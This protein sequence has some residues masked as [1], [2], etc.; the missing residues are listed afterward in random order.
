MIRSSCA[1]SGVLVI[2]VAAC[3][4]TAP[5][6]HDAPPMDVQAAL[7][8]IR[9]VPAFPRLTFIRPVWL[10]AAPDE[11][12]RL[13]VI[14]QPGRILS[15][16]NRNDVEET[17]VFL[18]ISERVFMGHNEEGLL[19]LAFH[20]QYADNG[21]FYV[22][23]STGDRQSRRTVLSRFNRSD[24]GPP[25]LR[26]DPESEQIILEVD[27]PFGNHNGGDIHFGPDG[28]LY[29][30]IG[31]GGGAGDPV[32]AGQDL[33]TLLA[34]IIRIDVD[35][36]ENDRPYAIPPDNPFVDREGARPEIW[37]YG[38]RNVWRMAFDR[39]TGT[40]WAADVGQN[41][42]EMVYVIERGGNYGWP[43]VEGS[44]PYRRSG[45]GEPPDPIIDPVVE[46]PHRWGRSITGGFVYRG[47]ENSGL[48]GAYIYV[49]YVTGRMAAVRYEDG[50]VKAQRDILSPT[51]SRPHVTTFGED[52][53]RE[54]YVCVF[55]RLDGREGRILR[56]VEQGSP[57]P[58]GAGG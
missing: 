8:D 14:E 44:N 24:D 43:I 18:D 45:D 50:E 42:W 19:A 22:W 55:D 21:R 25:H 31:D 30:S 47:S 32:N 34:T 6:A 39:E 12:N 51:R 57:T 27:Q 56:I 53:A 3:N 33:S 49:D 7:P 5:G 20:P 52:A 54:L 36:T 58:G 37:A 4:G 2:L 40:L 23:Y 1:I 29:L 17:S 9:L 16:E 46:Y 48:V 41:A 35:R 10:G 28:Y 15:F 26:A 38:L 11:T 13:F